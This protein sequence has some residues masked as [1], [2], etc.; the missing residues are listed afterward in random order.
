M[1]AKSCRVSYVDRGKTHSVDV[2]AETA[3]EAAVL[4][5]KAFSKVRGMKGPR[6]SSSLT[7]EVR[8]LRTITV[9]VSAV[10]TWLYEK[11]GTTADQQRI[12][13]RLREVIAGYR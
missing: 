2:I 7:I 4:A 9:R 5:L 10:W 3:Y 1:T 8:E 11:P 12:K 6:R 13:L